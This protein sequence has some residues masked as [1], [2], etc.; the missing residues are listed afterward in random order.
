MDCLKFDPDLVTRGLIMDKEHGNLI[1]V[2]R[3]GLVKRA[4]HGTRMLGWQDIRALYGRET[5]NLRNE[6]RWMF[7]NT[8]FSVSEAVMY[9]QLVDRLD[10]GAF[11]TASTMTY[12]S[13][14]TLWQKLCSTLPL[15]EAKGGDPEDPEKFIELDGEMVQTLQDQR[16]SGKQLLLIT[17]SDYQY[18]DRMMSFAYNRFMPQ[19]N[20]WRDLF[21]VVIVMARKPDFFNYQMSLYEVVTE[22][23]LMKPVLA[24]ERG[25]L[26]CGGSARVV[27]KAIGVEGDDILYVGDHIYTDA[28]LAKLNF[29]WRTALIIRELEEEVSA[30]VKGR[31]H[32]DKLKEL[33]EK[34]ELVGDLFNQLRLARQRFVSGVRLTSTF[35]DEDRLNE[36][37]A[38][39]LMVMEVLDDKIGPM[40]GYLSRAGL[41]DKS[42][43]IRQIEKYADIY[44]SRVSNFQRY[45]PYMYFRSPS[46]SLAHDRGLT[47]YY[48]KKYAE[49]TPSEDSL[50][51][52]GPSSS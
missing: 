18:T 6:G 37:L 14:Y 43:L 47:S 44:T 21:D 45:T 34:K 41:N 51:E 7:L 20:T 12:K 39:L 38:Q 28:A 36:T 50:V 17:N 10:Q 48:Q 46:Q 3:F 4:M 29:R 13:L 40:W 15:R 32:R 42:Q 9:M 1:K 22:D 33:M 5:V 26:F 27:E 24:A 19:G 16:D 52:Q 49:L 25:G 2:D 23:G 30:L 8:L 31:P 11:S 35:E